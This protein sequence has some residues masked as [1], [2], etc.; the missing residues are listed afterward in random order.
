MKRRMRVFGD[1]LFAAGAVALVVFVAGL[2]AGW[3]VRRDQ[4]GSGD[5]PELNPRR[6][7]T[8]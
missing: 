1:T 5:R 4:Q 3:S 7:R 2:T 8:T 6:F